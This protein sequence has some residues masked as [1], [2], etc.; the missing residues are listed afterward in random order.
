MI[1]R[2]RE[3]APHA[4]VS[5]T[6]LVVNRVCGPL[7]LYP[8]VPLDTESGGTLGPIMGLTTSGSLSEVIAN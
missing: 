8:P 7:S 4:E 1:V 3:A 5:V 6:R 2:G